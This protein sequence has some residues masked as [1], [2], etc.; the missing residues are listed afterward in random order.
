MFIRSER[1]FLR[2]SWPE[3]W[4]DLFA[5]I[6]DEGVIRNLAMAP[7][8][9]TPE[10]AKDFARREQERLL[11]NFLITLPGANGAELIGSIGLARKPDEVELGYWIARS[12]W[13]QGYASEAARAVLRLADAL[14]HRRVIAHHFADNPASGRVLEKVGFRRTGHAEQR[15]SKGRGQTA[16]SVGLVRDAESNC[17]Q[18][19]G[20][21]M[22]A[23]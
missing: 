11:P 19:D 15:F 18:D 21:L 14:G 22:R 13:H 12:H 17:D 10:D 9:Y 2:P 8:P 7:W 3:D 5:A 6:A 20:Q 16:L 23:A 4:S 1:L